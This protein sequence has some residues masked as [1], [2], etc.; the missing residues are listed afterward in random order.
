MIF[1]LMKKFFEF[2]HWMFSL[3]FWTSKKILSIITCCTHIEVLEHLYADDAAYIWEHAKFNVHRPRSAPSL[4]SLKLYTINLLYKHAE[5]YYNEPATCLQLGL[6]SCNWVK[7]LAAVC[8]KF[9]GN[10]NRN[11]L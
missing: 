5:K 11:L 9:T 3:L 4:I 2:V 1:L 7:T 10:C 8:C 6:N